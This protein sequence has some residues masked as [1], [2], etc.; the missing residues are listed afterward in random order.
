M[1]HIARHVIAAALLIA[2]MAAASGCASDSAQPVPQANSAEVRE[3][4]GGDAHLAYD[5]ACHASR[6]NPGDSKA[7]RAIKRHAPAAA[8]HWA[9][10]ARLAA[11]DGRPGDAW[12]MAMRAMEIRP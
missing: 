2:P 11:T 3:N 8:A 10:Q 4:A 1:K 5:R 7:A 9:A 6:R 12:K